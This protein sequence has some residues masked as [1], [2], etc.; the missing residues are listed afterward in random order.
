[1]GIAKFTGYCVSIALLEPDDRH[2]Y[3]ASCSAML[4]TCFRK[5]K[6][7]SRMDDLMCH[8]REPK[9]YLFRTEQL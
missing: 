5:K 3:D 1:M 2:G 8:A 6:T 9:R 7:I 4:V